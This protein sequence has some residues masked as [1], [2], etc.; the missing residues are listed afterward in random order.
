MKQKLPTRQKK[1]TDKP[2]MRW[3]LEPLWLRLREKFQPREGLKIGNNLEK[4]PLNVQPRFLS[5]IFQ[6]K[7]TP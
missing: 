4:C 1:L 6:K 2:D 5:F 7:N 3:R